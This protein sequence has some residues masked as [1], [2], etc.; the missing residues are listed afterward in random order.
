MLGTILPPTPTT[1]SKNTPPPPKRQ[2]DSGD[3]RR[4]TRKR[5][6]RGGIATVAATIAAAFLV[7]AVAVAAAT[8]LILLSESL[9]SSSSVRCYDLLRAALGVASPQPARRD[10]AT[11]GAPSARGGDSAPQRSPPVRGDGGGGGGG[12]AV[13]GSAAAKPRLTRFEGGEGLPLGAEVP[14]LKV[15]ARGRAKKRKKNTAKEAAE[16]GLDRFEA[17][18]N[19]AEVGGEGGKGRRRP[20]SGSPELL[21]PHNDEGNPHLYEADGDPYPPLSNL[22]SPDGS[23][24]LPD[25]DTSFLLDF[26]IA[27]FPKCGT[28]SL[29]RHLERSGLADVLVGERCDMTAEGV[30]GAASI[31]RALYEEMPRGTSQTEVGPP[32][33]DWRDN[34]RSGGRGHE[35]VVRDDSVS[36]GNTRK[37][38]GF[39]CP[40]DMSSDWS[41]PNYSRTFPNVS[42][43]VGIRH[44]LAFFQSLYN[45]RVATTPGANILPPDKLTGMCVRGSLGVCAW[46]ASF[47]DFLSRAGK[48]PLNTPEERAL[49]P[50][51]LTAVG[52]GGGVGRVFLYELSQLSD[53]GGNSNRSEEF[54]RDLSAFLGLRGA[55]G[56]IPRLGIEDVA[57]YGDGFILEGGG[58]SLVDRCDEEHGKIR[59]VL[60]EKARRSSEWIRNYFLESDEVVVSSRDFLVETL[61]G[62]MEDP[63]ER[64]KTDKSK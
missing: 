33:R 23:E 58:G 30:S 1:G 25:A 17:A 11:A 62:W 47:A 26:V 22:L 54:R 4:R 63:C 52:K 59:A 40:Q 61:R 42:L 57:L 64:G 24:V 38:R 3:G 55:L 2:D 43:V 28:T 48:T 20:G 13:E 7:V 29:L 18:R 35:V 31:V 51:N 45:F 60:I 8:L 10:G 46:R 49:L 15:G 41:L 36:S 56:P 19:S 5:K 16:E 14:P 32:V 37:P 9:P 34:I 53:D 27:G 21:P 44:P 12:S 50:L 39:K 6:R